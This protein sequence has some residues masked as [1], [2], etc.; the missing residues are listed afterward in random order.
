M[1]KRIDRTLSKL[2]IATLIF[3][4]LILGAVT[5]DLKQRLT[6]ADQD[7]QL[8]SENFLRYR[9]STQDQFRACKCFTEWHGFVRVDLSQLN[10]TEKE[11]SL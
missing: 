10:S 9:E 11:T 8:L 3:P 5:Y 2:S 4:S 1:A 7:Y 6:Q